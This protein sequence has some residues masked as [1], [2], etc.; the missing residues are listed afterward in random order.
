[1]KIVETLQLNGVDWSEKILRSRLYK[2]QEAIVRVARGESEP[3]KIG[4]GVRQGCSLSP[5]FFS[6][7]SDMMMREAM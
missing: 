7:Y 4:R 3:C 1:V 2:E 6:I 5:I